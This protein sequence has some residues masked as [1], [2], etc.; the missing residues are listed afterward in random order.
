MRIRPSAGL[1]AAVTAANSANKRASSSRETTSSRSRTVA[2]RAI[3]SP[4]ALTKASSCAL[5]A[6]VRAGSLE[7]PPKVGSRASSRRVNDIARVPPTAR[8][9][10]VEHAG[11]LVTTPHVFPAPVARIQGLVFRGPPDLA[12]DPVFDRISG[13]GVVFKPPAT[14]L[15]RHRPRPKAPPAVDCVRAGLLHRCRRLRRSGVGRSNDRGGGNSSMDDAAR[16][17]LPSRTP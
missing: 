7:R 2:R 1:S 10:T 4:C 9:G 5:R 12:G 13:P 17:W 3:Q 6:P 11:T 8:A 16:A 15:L 14:A